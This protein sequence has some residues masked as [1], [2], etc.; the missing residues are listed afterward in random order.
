MDS[1]RK[2]REREIERFMR[3]GGLTREAEAAFQE[4]VKKTAAA[5][6]EEETR[7]IQKAERVPRPRRTISIASVGLWLI[8]LAVA[9]FVFSMP[10][11][12][13]VLLLFGAGAILWDV[14]FKP[15]FKKNRC[16]IV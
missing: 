13:A 14:V 5:L 11:A 10:G 1:E 12:G 16:K 7:R 2:K 15:S 9:A 6:F 4:E 3:G 8:V